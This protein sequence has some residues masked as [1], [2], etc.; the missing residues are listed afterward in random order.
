MN[1]INAE[2][3]TSFEQNP[4]LLDGLVE[5]M[6]LNGYEEAAVSQSESSVIRVGLPQNGVLYQHSVHRLEEDGCW[7]TFACV[8]RDKNAR[9]DEMQWDEVPVGRAKT[10]EG[11][12]H[13]AIGYQMA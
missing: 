8:A 11:A 5:A 10:L 9:P 13:L 2:S 7:T 4:L 12:A 3:Q 6:R 1:R